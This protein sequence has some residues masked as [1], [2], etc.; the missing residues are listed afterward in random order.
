MFP[1]RPRLFGLLA[2]LSTILVLGLRGPGRGR[3]SARLDQRGRR[4]GRR[5]QSPPA[6]RRAEGRPR[7]SPHRRRRPCDRGP[8]ADR[9]HDPRAIGR[10][11]R[12]LAAARQDQLVGHLTVARAVVGRR[13]QRGLRPPGL[14]PSLH[15]EQ[16]RRLAR[17]SHPGR[18]DRAVDLTRAH[19]R[20][21]AERRLHR[22]DE[23]NERDHP[24]RLEDG[25]G[26][27]DSHD[28][29]RRRRR[30][31]PE[32]R[33]VEQAARRLRA[34][35]RDGPRPV[36]RDRSQRHLEDRPHRVGARRFGAAPGA[37]PCAPRPRCLR[38]RP[39]ERAAGDAR[40]QRVTVPGGRPP[41][42]FRRKAR[43]RTSR[44]TRPTPS[45]R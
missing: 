39:G 19:H 38:A 17:R 2:A 16:D 27:D 12:H 45:G 26:L 23:P 6:R 44:S 5:R 4:P 15:L 11:D 22:P 32:D 18:L 25:L 24:D 20:R 8:I 30:A 36:L 7:R 9:P 21:H 3:R 34:P 37:G 33:P 31:V 42:A 35:L 40:H 41:R 14:R 10:C 43:A 13:R 1:R 28:R 29:D